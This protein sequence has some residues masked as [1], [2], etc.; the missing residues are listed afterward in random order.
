MR[1]GL[2]PAAVADAAA[3]VRQPGVLPV[4]QLDL[5]RADGERDRP[6]EQRTAGQAGRG[7]TSDLAPAP[8]ADRVAARTV[9]RLPRR[10]ETVDRPSRGS[11]PRAGPHLERAPGGATTRSRCA[12]TARSGGDG[13][14]RARVAR[15]RARARRRRAADAGAARRGCRRGRRAGRGGCRARPRRRRATPS[16]ARPSAAA[17]VPARGARRAR[18]AAPRDGCGRGRAA[19]AAA[20]ARPRAGARRGRT[21]AGG[22]CRSRRRG[23]SRPGG[24]PR[25]R[26]RARRHG[27]LAPTSDV[28]ARSASAGS[29]TRVRERH[30]RA[31]RRR[32]RRRAATR[33]ARSRRGRRRTRSAPRSAPTSSVA[34]SRRS[35]TVSPAASVDR[36]GREVA[37]RRRARPSRPSSQARFAAHAPT[38][39]WVAS[40][41][42]RR[43]IT[44]RTCTAS[45]A[46]DRAEV[47]GTPPA[48]GRCRPR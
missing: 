25:R 9:E 7:S 36:A 48:R 44:A 31:L 46:A 15:G 14:R 5:A 3:V 33:A 29:E 17:T 8:A 39:R 37:A 47:A 4:D 38:A 2:E 24:R 11:R 43:S 42:S 27:P 32:R 30:D 41:R 12:T 40:G 45:P 19:R 1:A 21:A 28:G 34:V 6:G 20:R 22:P 18:R 10:P 13:Q 16:S 26:R 35:S 23:R